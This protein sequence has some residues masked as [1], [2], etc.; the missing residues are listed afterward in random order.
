MCYG[1][2]SWFEKARAKELRKAQERIDAL[3]K[4]TAEPAPAMQ[5]KEPAKPVEERKKVPA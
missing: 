5:S 4:R 3:N 1:Y 2:S